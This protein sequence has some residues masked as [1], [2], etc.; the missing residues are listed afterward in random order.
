MFRKLESHGFNVTTANN[1][2]EA[3]DAM[4]KAPKPSTR[5]KGAFNIVLMDQEMPVM[6]GNA[7]AREIREMERK[8]SV[9][10]VPIL[11]V[12]ANVRKAQQDDML[13][14]GMDD[15]IGKPYKIGEMI[16]KI[17]KIMESRSDSSG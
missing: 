5:D 17:N 7:A 1:G 9:E 8:G 10:H 12:T 6:D 11:G 2:R 13:E 16:A 4:L 3:V 14:S 15:V